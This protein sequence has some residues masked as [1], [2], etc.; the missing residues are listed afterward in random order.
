MKRGPILALIVIAIGIG[1]LISAYGDAGTYGNFEASLEQ[2]GKEMKVVGVLS[3]D[4][5]VVYDPEV[6]PNL[7]SF[8]MKD[9]NGDEK[10]VLMN[11]AKPTDFNKSEKIVLTGKMVGDN[12]VASD[13]LLKCPSKYKDEEIYVRGKQG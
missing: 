7:F 4:K 10:K 9:D 6:D 2:P 8:Y 12:F 3:K 1:V 13:M 5:E 11:A